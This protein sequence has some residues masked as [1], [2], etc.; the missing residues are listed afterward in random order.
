[1]PAPQPS[2]ATA[3]EPP[4]LPAVPGMNDMLANYLRTFA[5]WARSSL[6]GKLSSSAAAPGVLLQAYDAAPGTTP[7][8][9]LVR[10]NTAG[11]VS[12]LS[13]PIG[14]HYPGGPPATT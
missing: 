11:V 7:A 4:N 8:V 10:V 6:A 14:G 12:T 13:V 2:P 3:R 1:V 5:L 9:W